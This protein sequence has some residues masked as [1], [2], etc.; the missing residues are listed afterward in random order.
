M[1]EWGDDSFYN[2]L[3]SVKGLMYKQWY[4]AIKEGKFLPPIE[5]S[6]DPVN[7]CNL[8]CFW[9]NGKEPKSR[10]VMMTGEHLVG[11][12][13]FVK[14]W[15]VKAICVAGGGEP[16]M[17]PNLGE[18]FLKAKEID[19]PIA[20]ITNGLFRDH[21]QIVDVAKSA[22]WVGVS[23]DCAKDTT[24]QCIKGADRFH[25]VLRNISELKDAGCKEVTYKYLIH[26]M[27]QYE[28]YDAVENAVKVGAN[29]IH[30]RPISF[31]N[32]QDKVEP[33]DIEMIEQQIDDAF[34]YY[35]DKI[36]IMAI[37][38][39]YDEATMHAILPFK[40]CKVTPI[41]PIFQ[42]NGDLSVCIDQ[43]W[44]KDLVICK[45]DSFDEVLK[46]WGSDHHKAVIDKINVKDCPKCT[47]MPFNVQYER[48]I[49]ND[50]FLWKFT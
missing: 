1:K 12:I 45:H 13:Q 21:Q 41:M 46:T 25:E 32:Y 4:D 27:N 14:D 16:T 38:H 31:L 15:G 20:M 9:C 5:A 35:G 48:A 10:K 33:Y 40:K 42:A 17:H 30:I 26:P 7:D 34:K 3:N 23:V 8:N 28:I 29:R 6:I 50:E 24:F 18:A 39:K 36:K 11:M 2:P 44:R 49:E 22:E 47:F 37:R 19:M 43:K